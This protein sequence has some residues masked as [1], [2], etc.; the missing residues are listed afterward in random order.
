MNDSTET[1]CTSGFISIEEVRKLELEAYNRSK[2]AIANY[3]KFYNPDPLTYFSMEVSGPKRARLPGFIK[4]HAHDL[5]L[6]LV[7]FDCEKHWFRETVKFVVEGHTSKINEF[8]EKFYA[9]VND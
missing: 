9:Y 2:Q 5:G 4:Y 7:E 8:K 6:T 3:E 1:F